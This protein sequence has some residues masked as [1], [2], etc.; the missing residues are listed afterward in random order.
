[1]PKSSP[2]EVWD[3]FGLKIFE[4]EYSEYWS[5]VELHKLL[6]HLVMERLCQGYIVYWRPDDQHFTPYA[7]S[8]LD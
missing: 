4:L 6:Q 5:N 2:A 7:V 3:I 8:S 1:V